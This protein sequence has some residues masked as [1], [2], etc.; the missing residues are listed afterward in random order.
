MLVNVNVLGL[1]KVTVA[2]S[3]IGAVTDSFFVA[4]GIVTSPSSPS[5][6]TIDVLVSDKLLAT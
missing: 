6:I 5:V 2:P 4:A 1:D 3:A